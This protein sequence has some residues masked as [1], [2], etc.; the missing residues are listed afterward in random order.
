MIENKGRTNKQ[1]EIHV[2]CDIMTSL[3]SSTDT[4]KSGAQFNRDDSA[5]LIVSLAMVVLL[6]L[7]GR[8][9]WLKNV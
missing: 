2:M 1:M 9:A 6:F 4:M 3:I 5:T 8:G 7:I